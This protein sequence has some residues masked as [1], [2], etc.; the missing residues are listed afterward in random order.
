MFRIEKPLGSGLRG[1]VSSETEVYE[2]SR[3]SFTPWSRSTRCAWS[4]K[5]QSG[6]SLQGASRLYEALKM[7]EGRAR[8]RGE[9]EGRCPGLLFLS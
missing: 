6:G 9:S 2:D 1:H 8:Q 5:G 7:V 3:S 4:E